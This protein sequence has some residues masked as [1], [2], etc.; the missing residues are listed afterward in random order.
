MSLLFKAR[1]RSLERMDVETLAP[2]DMAQVLR[3]ID[4]VSEGIG[5]LDDHRI[6]HA[7]LCAGIEQRRL[8]DAVDDVGAP[9]DQPVDDLL[10]QLV[11]LDGNDDPRAVVAVEADAADAAAG[12]VAERKFVAGMDAAQRARV[13][14]V[15]EQA[16]QQP[17]A[18]AVLLEDVGNGLAGADRDHGPVV[19]DARDR[20]IFI[21]ERIGIEHRHRQLERHQAEVRLVRRVCAGRNRCADHDRGRTADSGCDPVATAPRQGRSRSTLQHA[22]CNASMDLEIAKVGGE[23]RLQTC[24]A[25]DRSG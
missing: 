3:E 5:Q 23:A 17:R 10:V 24:G 2:A 8:D 9:L 12:V 13:R 7:G 21:A 4:V 19:V 18:D 22:H 11:V 14:L 1:S 25:G 15:V 20:R 16:L 6:V